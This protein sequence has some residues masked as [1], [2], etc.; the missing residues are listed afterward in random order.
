MISERE[1]NRRFLLQTTTLYLEALIAKTPEVLRVSPNLKVTF[2]GEI[3][4]LGK[5]ELWRKTLLIPQ[6]QTFADPD[7]N[8]VVFFGIVTNEVKTPPDPESAARSIG[9]RSL[10]C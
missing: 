4:E 6:R 8:N 10:P 1:K 2:N 3:S 9:D 7:T 5:N